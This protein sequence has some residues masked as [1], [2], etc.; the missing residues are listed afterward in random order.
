MHCGIVAH[1][2][3]AHTECPLVCCSTCKDS[4]GKCFRLPAAD[5]EVGEG[6][7]VEAEVLFHRLG[8]DVADALHMPVRDWESDKARWELDSR[9]RGG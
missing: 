3:V 5:D 6:V 1:G 4:R 8:E 2:S 7:D 9:S